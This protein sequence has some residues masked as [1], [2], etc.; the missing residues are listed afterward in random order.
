MMLSLL[1]SLVHI[2][3]HGGNTPDPGHISRDFLN[4]IDFI[5]NYHLGKFSRIVNAEIPERIPPSRVFSSVEH[6]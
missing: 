6:S 3:D 4:R 1:S 5:G 2:I